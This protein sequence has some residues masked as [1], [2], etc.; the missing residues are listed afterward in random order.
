MKKICNFQYFKF[1]GRFK[2]INKKADET[3][4]SPLIRLILVVLVLA[5]VFF[6]LVSFDMFKFFKNLPDLLGGKSPPDELLVNA[7]VYGI[8]VKVLLNDGDGRCVVAEILDSQGGNDWLKSYGVKKGKLE[9][10][11]KPVET[12]QWITKDMVEDGEKTRNLIDGEKA[13]LEK[14]KDAYYEKARSFGGPLR[15]STWDPDFSPG[16]PE[17]KNFIGAVFWTILEN[18]KLSLAT[19]YASTTSKEIKGEEFENVVKSLDQVI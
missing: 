5:I 6:G 7:V 12:I 8:D 15:S 17:H 13:V 14:I 1:Q 3:K 19:F 9:I 2:M 16:E 4:I 11:K 18:E 10:N